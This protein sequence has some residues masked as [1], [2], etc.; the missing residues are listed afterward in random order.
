MSDE[1]TAA[2][3]K[4]PSGPTR[5][6]DLDR[7]AHDL[8]MAPAEKAFAS[9]HVFKEIRD[10]KLFKYLGYA[11]FEVYIDILEA[12]GFKRAT[13]WSNINL[14]E[15]FDEQA[16]A[17]IGVG[18][19]RMLGANYV[20]DRLEI[21]E[22][23]FPVGPNG[24][25]KPVAQITAANLRRLLKERAR[26]EGKLERKA[27]KKKQDA[28]LAKK[29]DRAI[30]AMVGPAGTVTAAVESC[31]P[32]HDSDMTDV[33]AGVDALPTVDIPEVPPEANEEDAAASDAVM[34]VVDPITD[35][36]T[37]VVAADDAGD[38]ALAA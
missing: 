4:R 28:V 31:P 7:R 3:Q 16:H 27:G 14:V 11:T 17:H 34:S 13:I 23:G 8:L 6:R 2:P 15:K 36:S 30:E 1:Q 29:T 19:L 26:K 21:V 10:D 18:R 22:K 12:E 5:A 24:E 33:S 35:T 20:E 25:R 38:L 37:T 9:G 32:A